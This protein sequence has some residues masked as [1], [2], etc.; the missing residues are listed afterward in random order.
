MSDSHGH[1]SHGDEK[2][3]ADVIELPQAKL[4]SQYTSG[5]HE[6]DHTP[7]KNLFGFLAALVVILLLTAAG[8]FQLF[9]S[10]ADGD[11]E[12]AANKPS[13]EMLAMHKRDSEIADH[14]GKVSR[15]GKVV[16]YRMPVPE[17][18][19]LVVANPARFAAAPPPAD[20]VHP[21]DAAK[22]KPQ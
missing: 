14:W 19:R 15:E 21:D 4:V 5:G 9:V 13:A 11:L 16:G 20:W 6:I 3:G 8:V 1:D 17:A 18:A 10:H 7:N 22:P 2:K 12:R